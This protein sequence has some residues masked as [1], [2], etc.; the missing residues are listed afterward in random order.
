MIHF[1]LHWSDRVFLSIHYSRHPSLPQSFTA[2]LPPACFTN[3]SHHR[4]LPGLPSRIF[5]GNRCLFFRP[6]RSTT[7]VDAAYCYRPSNVVC[8]SVCRS[9]TVYYMVPQ[10]EIWTDCKK[11]RINWHV[12][13]CSCLGR[14]VPWTLDANCTGCRSHN[15]LSSK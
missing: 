3:S 12:L 4:L 15:E 8:R 11:F 1:I 5:C 10:F 9:V 7:Y 14:R 13:F 2:G 6:H